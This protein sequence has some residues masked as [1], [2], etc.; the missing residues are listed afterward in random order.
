MLRTYDLRMKDVIS[1]H[2]GRKLG[3][4]S[5]IEFDLESGK[6]TALVVPGTGKFFGLFTRG[7]DIVIPWHK[8]NKIGAD[9]ILVETN[10]IYTVKS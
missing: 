1:I 4:V 6:M 5:D 2:D 7:E 3:S 9:V 10:E 8:I